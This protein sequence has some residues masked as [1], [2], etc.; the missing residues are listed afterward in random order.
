M[1]TQPSP[2][3]GHSPQFLAYVCSGQMAGWIKMPLGMEVGLGPCN[4]VLD[5]DPAPPPKKTRHSPQFSDHVWIKMPLCTEVGL[6][7]CDIVLDGDPAPSQKRGTV[8]QFS[9]HVYCGQ[10]VTHLSYCWGLVIVFIGIVI[11]ACQLE[12]LYIA[13][14]LESN[15]MTVMFASMPMVFYFRKFLFYVLFSSNRLIL[16]PVPLQFSVIIILLTLYCFDT[17]GWASGR[18]SG[19]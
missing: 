10:M 1:G 19:L 11:L 14:M 17:V 7:P 8:P 4:I 5:G 16:I 13:K 6:G 15:I 9:A 2:H 18:L 3:K 12:L